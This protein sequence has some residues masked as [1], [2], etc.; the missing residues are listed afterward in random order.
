MPRYS[1]WHGSSEVFAQFAL[2]KPEDYNH[3]HEW[4]WCQLYGGWQRRGPTGQEFMFYGSDGQAKMSEWGME[5]KLY[6]DPND[7]RKFE[8]DGYMPQ[9]DI[10]NL[11]TTYTGQGIILEKFSRG[12]DDGKTECGTNFKEA[13][14]SFAVSMGAME[15]SRTGKAVWVPKYWK[16]IPWY[17]DN[18]SKFY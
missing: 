16:D 15:S 4:V 17:E 2:A 7:S 8:E 13:F 6:I 18:P 3:R 12:I 5:C 14:K 11:G 9:Q 10:E 1:E